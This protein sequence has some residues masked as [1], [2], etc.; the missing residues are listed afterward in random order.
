VLLALLW[1]HDECTVC[2]T[3]PHQ[4]IQKDLFKAAMEEKNERIVCLSQSEIKHICD[5]CMC[6]YEVEHPDEEISHG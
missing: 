3:V 5:G 4:G 2:L 1:D 6:V